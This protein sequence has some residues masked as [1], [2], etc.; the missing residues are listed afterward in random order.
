MRGGQESTH[1]VSVQV[2]GNEVV[3]S[4]TGVPDHLKQRVLSRKSPSEILR[5]F[6]LPT[7]KEWTLEDVAKEAAREAQVDLDEIFP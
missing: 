5:A 4:S 7:P 6:P 2:L 3:S 1:D